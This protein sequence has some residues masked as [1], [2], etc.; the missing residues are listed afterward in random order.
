MKGKKTI[1]TADLGNLSNSVTNI[2]ENTC[3]LLALK[4][5]RFFSL[6]VQRI[7]IAFVFTQEMLSHIG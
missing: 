5:K 3:L 4:C 1:F 7:V 6:T 2:K